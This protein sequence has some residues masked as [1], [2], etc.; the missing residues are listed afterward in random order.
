MKKASG[1]HAIEHW[2]SLDNN[3]PQLPEYRRMFEGITNIITG[4]NQNVVQAT[5]AAARN[6][7][8]NIIIYF[9][10]D[11]DCLANWDKEL[12]KAAPDAS[13]YLLWVNDGIQGRN[14][15]LTIPIMSAGLYKCLG[16]FWHPDY[17]S[18]WVDVDLWHV[19]N[20]RQVLVNAQHLTFEHKHYSVGKA[21]YDQTYR[22]HDNAQRQSQGRSI[23][24]RREK[25]NFMTNGEYK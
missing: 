24:K 18:M 11:F 20:R 6:A 25:E 8:G 10:D 23:I 4:D 3:D 21:D 19:C 5:N 2:L 1:K 9:S 13:E 7:T 22:E 14:T 17:Q 15:V 12:V 16:Y